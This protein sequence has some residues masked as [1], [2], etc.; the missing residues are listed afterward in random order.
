MIWAVLLLILVLLAV[1]PVG[2]NAVY[3]VEGA[4]VRLIAG[5]VR[6]LIYPKQRKKKQ[7]L[8]KKA[9]ANKQEQPKNGAKSGGSAKDFFPL[10][11][12]I[13]KFL[14]ELRTKLR[15]DHLELKLILA[16]DD[17]C[18]L[19]VHYGRAWAALGNLM[20]QLE[21]VFVIKK[22]DIEVECDFTAQD[23]VVYARV[24]L[25]ITVAG[26]LSLG[27]RHGWHMIREYF[28]IMNERK[29]GAKL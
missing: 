19:A 2:I 27:A 7:A 17:P 22:R 25:T 13:L 18:D 1:M 15:V 5:P 9:E 14:G 28:R 20:P 12:M 4:A 21:R 24:D 10:V 23:T 8:R 3:G 11:S 16:G 29:G 6:L 26:I